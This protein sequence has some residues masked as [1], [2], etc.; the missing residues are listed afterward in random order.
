M[1]RFETF[2]PIRVDFNSIEEDGLLQV[3]RHAVL[4]SDPRVGEP[5]AL[6]DLEGHACTAVVERVTARL[7]ALR[8]LW[9][10]WRPAPAEVFTGIQVT[11]TPARL[12]QPPFGEQITQATTSTTP[13]LRPAARPNERIVSGHPRWWH[14]GV[15]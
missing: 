10:T 8:P 11:S 6:E 2:T 3:S 12:H 5:L 14:T 4:V 13:P 15:A 7:L 9:Q 1:I